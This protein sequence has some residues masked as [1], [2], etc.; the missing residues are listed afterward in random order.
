M[1]HVWKCSNVFPIYKKSEET[2]KT[3]YRPV[4]LLTALSKVFERA[5]FDRMYEAFRCKLSHNLSGYLRGHSCYSAL[6]E[7][8]EGW[9]ASLMTGEKLSLQ[10]RWILARHSTQCVIHSSKL[11]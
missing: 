5:M 10:P 8:T 2:D 6:L 4:S 3:Y 7:M 11:N 9:R 1:V